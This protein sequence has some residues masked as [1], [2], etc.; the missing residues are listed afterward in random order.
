MTVDTASTYE[1]DESIPKKK[2]MANKNKL[3]T[4]PPSI[5]AVAVGNA[6]KDRPN[7]DEFYL[8]TGLFYAFK[9][10]TIHQTT[11]PAKKDIQELTSEII[12][13]FETIG[14]FFL[15]PDP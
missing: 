6:M 5:W 12:I 4:Y 3:H 11:N 8:A 7:N 2:I 14:E 13:A 15:F 9:C 1:K 10:P